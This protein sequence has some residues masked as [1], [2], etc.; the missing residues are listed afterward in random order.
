MAQQEARGGERGKEEQQFSTA[1]NE[2][3]R[4]RIGMCNNTTERRKGW[5]EGREGG[6]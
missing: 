5:K 4:A 6:K 2:W 1:C 3:Q